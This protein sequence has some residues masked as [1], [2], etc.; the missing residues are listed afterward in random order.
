MHFS[1]ASVM[2]TERNIV[3][4]YSDRLKSFDIFLTQSGL[5]FV[6]I[7]APVTIRG[8]NYTTVL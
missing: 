4:N 7:K 6:K 2:V 1:N 3:P 5:D 8:L